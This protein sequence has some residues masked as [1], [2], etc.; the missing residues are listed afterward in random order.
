MHSVMSATNGNTLGG[1]VTG[2]LTPNSLV[3][4]LVRELLAFPDQDQLGFDVLISNIVLHYI[5]KL[6]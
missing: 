2:R 4:T 6:R 1:V 3:K 5:Q